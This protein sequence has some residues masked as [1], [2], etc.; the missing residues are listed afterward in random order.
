MANDWT[1]DQLHCIQARG[2]TLLVSAA[3]GSGK[4]TVLVER[5]KRRLLDEQ[6]GVDINRLLVVTFT[7]AAAEEMK[8]RLR[9]A[10]TEALTSAPHDRRL[11]RQ[12]MLLP[13][14]NICTIDSFCATLVRE[15][16]EA[17]GV[18]P[19]FRVIDP[20]AAATLK[21]AAVA[22]VVE[23]YY[24]RC[25]TDFEQLV[26]LL[27]SPRSDRALLN[28]ILK[29]YEFSQ[30]FPSPE[31]WLRQQ[32]NA[33]DP[34]IPFSH[35]AWAPIL[36]DHA[37]RVFEKT[38]YLHAEAI[39]LSHGE[40]TLEEKY[41]PFLQQEAALFADFANR[42]RT[43]SLD[44]IRAILGYAMESM[45]IVRKAEP[46]RK[47]AAKNCRDQV[48]AEFQALAKLFCDGEEAFARNMQRGQGQLRVLIE[49]T[50]L[51]TQRYAEKKADGDACDFND[52][53]HLALHLLG[54]ADS[55]GHLVRTP[56][57]I[58]LA[59]R[60]DEVLIDEYQDTNAAQDA[61]FSLLTRDER[62]LFMVGDVKQSIYG[63]R[64]ARP[65]L[66]IDRRRCSHPYD[67]VQYPAVITLGKNFRSRPQITDA[68]NFV[69]GQL[70][71]TDT[72]GMDYGKD[73]QLI[74][75]STVYEPHY[76]TELWLLQRDK[77]I[78]TE[79]GEARLIARRIREL[80]DEAVVTEKEGTRRPVPGDFCILLRSKNAHC[81]P[82]IEELSACGITAYT[83]QNTGLFSAEDVQ[84]AVAWLRY[85]DNPRLDIPLVSLLLS[86][87]CGFTPDDLARI[88]QAA[89]KEALFGTAL[90][91]AAEADS[92]LGQRC[93]CLLERIERYRLLATSQSADRILNAV[94]EGE[95]LV[96][97][98]AARQNGT[99]CAANLHRLLEEARQFESNGFRGLSAFIRYLDRL[100]ESRS[101]LS[102]AVAPQE[103]AVALMS[104]H[105]SKGL[106][107]PF[108]FLAGLGTQFN[109][110]SRNG[111]LL[112]HSDAGIGLKR[113][114]PDTLS[115]L[116]TLQRTAISQAIRR[117]E[118][119]EELRVLYV[120]MTRA[121]DKLILIDSA[122]NCDSMLARLAVLVGH[123]PRLPAFAVDSANSLGQWVLMCALRHPS[124]GALRELA[125]A[126]ALTLVE[127][128]AAWDIH[129]EAPP[130]RPVAPQ[131]TDEV[132]APDEALLADLTQRV[133]YVYPY[134]AL[135]GLPV[136]AA[137]STL[138]GHGGTALIGRSR[139]AFVSASG[140]TPAERG[141]ALHTFMQ[142]ADLAAAERDVATEADRL[143]AHGLLRKAERDALDFRRVGA[144]LDSDIYRRMTAAEV[145]FREYA[146][147]AAFPVA[148]MR[149]EVAAVLPE[150][151]EGETLVVKGIAD[152]VFIE[153]GQLVIL[154]YKTDRVQ[155]AEQLIGL[156]REQLRIYAYA[157][158]RIFEC[159]VKECLLYSF[160]LSRTVRVE[161]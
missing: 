55:E 133:E 34:A 159:P 140:L 96:A 158:E 128:G 23:E 117:A 15:H 156:Y 59:E 65:Q 42:F 99:L 13:Q 107:F 36:R 90:R 121:K 61:L 145:S 130:E 38:A 44:E 101:D 67:G 132:I 118:R 80:C 25:D 40:P 151:G 4:T 64:Q 9:K 53:E 54:T 161:I 146:F 111:R 114:E 135:A 105:G 32:A 152:C 115:V 79:R 68:V 120:A 100:E 86:D 49:L 149:P 75:N 119:A 112:M 108:V 74:P 47:T 93:R 102:P 142:Y 22:E 18:S 45:P 33:Y 57:A 125:G 106:E 147:N 78:E 16:F 27:C 21:E 69:F 52:I 143:T 153:D 41:I 109:E 24:G 31:E 134:A 1:S 73:E 87:A 19:Q 62:N 3:A 157:L 123:A 92:E 129:I 51:F 148:V 138:A 48:R 26:M 85:I 91:R 104:I 122:K 160:Y 50:E 83:T 113:F 81:R 63:F 60:F 127:G 2:G 137:A 144:F 116:P 154:D 66:F 30:A 10:L 131:T 43:A 141:T 70:M 46:V 139:P 20:S 14:A 17:A 82:Y 95:G 12:L 72:A 89:G 39:R 98:A 8:S 77:D 71:S 5:V 126:Q 110:E 84:T 76:A 155:N 28:A 7:K 103:N 124:G 35:S 56:L 11:Q 150:G 88:R 97:A 94:Y 37:T 29:L 136:K 58:E 6:A